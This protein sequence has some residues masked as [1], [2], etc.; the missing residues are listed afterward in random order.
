MHLKQASLLSKKWGASQQSMKQKKDFQYKIET[1]LLNPIFLFLALNIIIFA[2]Y[3]LNI[4]YFTF[5]PIPRINAIIIFISVFLIVLGMLSAS[6]LF[7]SSKPIKFSKEI[8]Y[9]NSNK[10]KIVF[11]LEIL[12][13]IASFIKLIYFVKY[14]GLP[15][16]L[17]FFGQVRVSYLTGE[18][19]YPSIL[20]VFALLLWPVAI[21][22]F[23]LYKFFKIKVHL[24]HF[25]LSVFLLLVNN[26]IVSGR[27][28]IGFLVILIF[29]YGIYIDNV[30]IKKPIDKKKFLLLTALSFIYIILI[31]L[32]RIGYKEILDG[33]VYGLNE[34]VLYFLGPYPATSLILDKY[35]AGNIKN[36]F[37][38]FTFGGLV[39]YSIGLFPNIKSIFNSTFGYVPIYSNFN[40]GFNSFTY[41]AYLIVDFGIVGLL[42]FSFI[43]GF[44]ASYFYYK[45][46]FN[47]TILRLV[48]F[49]SIFVIVILYE[50]DIVTKW[51]SWWLC[52]LSI[53]MINQFV[54][55]KKCNKQSKMED[56]NE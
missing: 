21:T 56:K 3:N 32:S 46:K 5:I 6:F 26:M 47:F 38:L 29:L 53:P 24:K 13:V 17:G 48:L 55:I 7:L 9:N 19:T 22:H 49:V 14:F 16:S 11:I 12:A 34:F 51:V 54:R 18:F 36:T 39:R 27:G 43:I 23:V 30:I 44:L 33:I 35:L 20:D 45:L 28:Q 37:G 42:I 8:Y 31:A 52:L 40:Y 15:T 2:L 41:I 10:Y 4:Y 25:A 1:I 50:R